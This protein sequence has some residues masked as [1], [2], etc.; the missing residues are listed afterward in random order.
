MRH[1]CWWSLAV[2][3]LSA[4]HGP[5]GP[6]G[7]SVPQVSAVLMGSFTRGGK[8][9]VRN[10]LPPNAVSLA[11]VTGEA[12]SLLVLTPENGCGF[13]AW[14]ANSQSGRVGARGRTSEAFDLAHPRSWVSK[15]TG[16]RPGCQGGVAQSAEAYF[17]FLD[18]SLDTDH[19]GVVD[20]TVR[21]FTS[22]SHDAH[23]GDVQLRDQDGVFK[24]LDA[25]GDALSTTRPASPLQYAIGDS[26]GPLT[27]PWFDNNGTVEMVM[28]KLPLTLAPGSTNRTLDPAT[29]KVVFDLDLSQASLTASDKTSP[30]R[31][32]HTL[33]VPFLT[34]VQTHSG[35]GLLLSLT[36]LTAEEMNGPADPAPGNESG[37]IVVREVVD[38]GVDG[39]QPDAGP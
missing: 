38:G 36:P 3:A 2:A 21:I 11:N 23:F 28:T 6:G 17:N 20:A 32:A 4:C 15:G 8:R 30:A 27:V 26:H 14:S 33:S 34:D 19:D 13:G 31:V 22:E 29:R 16:L 5:D 24:W 12:D 1:V 37:Q 35:A 9:H 10:D 7:A 39:G 25:A 18:F